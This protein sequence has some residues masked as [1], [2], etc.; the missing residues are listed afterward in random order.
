MAAERRAEHGEGENACKQCGYDLHT[1]SAY[2]P[3]TAGMPRD[4]LPQRG[5]NGLFAKQTIVVCVATDPEPHEAIRRLDCERAIVKSG[6][7]GPER[8]NLLELKRG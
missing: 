4:G 2:S 3:I 8:S 7:S 1:A 5:S 6:P